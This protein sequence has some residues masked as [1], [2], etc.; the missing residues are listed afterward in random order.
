MENIGGVFFELRLW[1]RNEEDGK[2]GELVAEAEF[3]AALT[4]APRKSLILA[5]PLRYRGKQVGRALVSLVLAQQRVF[6]QKSCGALVDGEYRAARPLLDSFWSGAN[7]ELAALA[8]HLKRLNALFLEYEDTARWDSARERIQ[9]QILP[10]YAVLEEICLKVHSRAHN[11][12]RYK[13]QAQLEEGQ[14]LFLAILAEL[15]LRGPQT[16]GEL[17]G[18]A[19]RMS[20]MESLD[21]AQGLVDAL[22]NRPE[23]LVKQ[24]PP[25]PGSRTVRFVQLLCPDLHTMDSAVVAN[26]TIA[27]QAEQGSL[28][29]RVT[30][31]ETEIAQLRHIVESLQRTQTL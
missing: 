2:G 19:G 31:L 14:K 4:L 13:T 17:R 6:Q 21:V 7:P 16:I 12:F 23:P 3:E 5:E 26:A 8:S 10:C 22:M 15:L 18:R 20:P 11:A 24:I 9:S 30:A 29:D 28:S 1:K 25:S 27:P